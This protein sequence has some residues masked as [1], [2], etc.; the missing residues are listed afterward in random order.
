MDSLNAPVPTPVRRVV[1]DL[2]PRLTRFHSVREDLTLVVKRMAELDAG[3]HRL[4]ERLRH[5]LDGVEPIQ[6]NVDGL[7]VFRDPPTGQAPVVYLTVQSPGLIRLHQQLCESFGAVDGL[8]GDQYVPHITVARGGPSDLGELL[9]TDIPAVAWTIDELT[10]WSRE[11]R[12]AV[13]RVP[14]TG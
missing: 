6:A 12:A 4:R 5:L 1:S 11:Y 3:P 14:L 10:V 7:G 13:L 9:A 8:E 2:R